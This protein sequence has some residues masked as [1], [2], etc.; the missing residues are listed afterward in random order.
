MTT[1]VM[2]YGDKAW[3]AEVSAE[4]VRPLSLYA[5]HLAGV[6]EVVPAAA[7]V[8]VRLA[9]SASPIQIEETAQALA[10]FDASSTVVAP[11]DE[12]HSHLIEVIYDGADLAEIAQQSAMSVEA[13]ID[14]HM[15]GQ[16]RVAFCGFSPGFAYLTGLDPRLHVP[17]RSSP[18]T[19]V[20]AGSVA[21][22]SEYTAIYPRTSPG[23][24]LL[25]GCTQ[26]TMWDL[27]RDEPAL[28][29]PGDTVRFT[30]LERQR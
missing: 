17:R 7:T 3:L 21:I 26:Q 23:G 18:R 27:Q 20:P 13:V 15:A 1:K 22:A 25:L 24:W 29:K 16:Y 6:D 8:L 19:T 12:P 9:A 11:L 2:R 14:A 4:Q 28:L 5:A 30:T 10:D